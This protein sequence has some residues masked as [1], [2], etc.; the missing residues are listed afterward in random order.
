[1][2]LKPN[3]IIRTPEMI[4]SNI[5]T[6]YMICTF[7]NA[8]FLIRLYFGITEMLTYVSGA[9]I[10]INGKTPIALFGSF[11]A[12]DVSCWITDGYV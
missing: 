10:T 11:L 7:Y 8:L 12:M 9:N 5:M 1:M 4:T 2:A 3:F 6:T